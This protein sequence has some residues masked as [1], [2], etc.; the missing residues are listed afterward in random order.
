MVLLCHSNVTV[1]VKIGDTEN[2]GYFDPVTPITVTLDWS[3]ELESSAQ[4]LGRYEFAGLFYISW[5]RF[6]GIL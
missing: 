6:S 3:G 2:S 4:Y 5:R 1:P